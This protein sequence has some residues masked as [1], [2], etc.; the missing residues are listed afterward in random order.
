[1]QYHFSCI[2]LW[3]HDAFQQCSV[4]VVLFEITPLFQS[5]KSRF[6]R[7]FK[8]HI[9]SDINSYFFWIVFIVWVDWILSCEI[10]FNIMIAIKDYR[11][12]MDMKMRKCC[13]C[14]GLRTGA[15]IICFV[16][17]FEAIGCFKFLSWP[18]ARKFSF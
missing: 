11:K 3:F 9:N 18:I 14:F 8:I 17:F 6:L 12:K 2:L 16:S 5:C 4:S 13:C 1:M 10:N 15:L 7:Y